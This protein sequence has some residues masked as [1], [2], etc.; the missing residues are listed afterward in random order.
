MITYS[1]RLDTHEE[2]IRDLIS[3]MVAPAARSPSSVE[4]TCGS[5][6]DGLNLA[7]LNDTVF[8]YFG[9]GFLHSF[10]ALMGSMIGLI[11]RRPAM[12]YHI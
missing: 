9:I 11:A 3:S 2:V 7:S 6:L 10:E 8:T 12:F 5:T 4:F 1:R